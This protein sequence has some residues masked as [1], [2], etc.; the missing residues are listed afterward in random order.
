M[1]AMLVHASVEAAAKSTG[2]SS[3]TS[4]RWL[5]EPAIVARLRAAR[6][7]A[8][9]QAKALLQTALVEA[10]EQL[11]SLLRSAENEAVQASVAKTLLEFGFKA[12]EIG[13][14][15]ERLDK[16]EQIA[17]S[18]DWKGPNSDDHANAATEKN[19]GVN[20]HG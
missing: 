15:Q 17:K 8:V 14:I 7:D 18:H 1:A 20:G 16:L 5:R 12:V 6:K 10:V 2:I 4:W 9:E 13:D 3:V 11:R 19:R